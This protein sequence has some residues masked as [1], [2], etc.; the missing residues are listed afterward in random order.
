MHTLDSIRDTI[1]PRMPGRSRFRIVLLAILASQIVVSLVT[2]KGYELTTFGDLSTTVLLLCATLAMLANVRVASGT[3]R[4]FWI[5]MTAGFALW[6]I[7]NALWAWVEVVQRKEVPNPFA[8]DV[9]LFIHIV[10][11]VAALVLQPHRRGAQPK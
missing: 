10:P 6:T 8:G 5:L 1:L 11:L 9:I 7:D 3:S 2:H 4:T